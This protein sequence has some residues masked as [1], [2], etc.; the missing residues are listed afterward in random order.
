M[1]SPIT[2][3]VSTTE[4][5]IPDEHKS[6]EYRLGNLIVSDGAL[7]GE[8]LQLSNSAMF[9]TRSEVRSIL[10][11]LA[12]LGTEK[13]KGLACTVALRSY[14]GNA[15]QIPALKRC[16]RHNPRQPSYLRRSSAGLARTVA[17]PTDWITPPLENGWR[18]PGVSIPTSA[19]PSAL[20]TSERIPLTIKWAGCSTMLVVLPI[21]WASPR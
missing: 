11:A 7:T 9:S 4:P 19:M 14:L 18:P 20:T 1:T 21:R 13:V 3:P 8:I 16:W 15:L 5:P 6:A 17:R 10:Q 2:L 12:V